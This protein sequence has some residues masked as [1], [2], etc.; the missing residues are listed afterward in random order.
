MGT[1]TNFYKNPSFKY[2]KDLSLNSALQNLRAY[3]VATGIA[4]PT[5][6]I[7]SGDQKIVH[8][9]RRREKRPPP[10]QNNESMENDG[11][12]SHQDY[13]EKRRKEFNSSRVYH[14]LTAD[15]LEN[16]RPSIHLVEYDSD[17]STSSES[18]E[19]LVPRKSGMVLDS[20]EVKPDH[21]NSGNLDEDNRVKS[22]SEQRFAVPGEPVCVV[23]GKYGEYI[24]D[25]TNDDI[26][27][28]DCKAELLENIKLSEGYLSNQR[29]DESLPRPNSSR[30]VEFGG[31][32]WDHNRLRWSKK[33]SSLCTYECWKCQRPGHLAEDCLV[34]ISKRQYPCSDEPCNQV[35]ISQKKSISIS[36]DLLELY[37]R[38]HQIGKNLSTAKCNGCSRSSTL[39]ACLDCSTTFCDSAGHLS[40]HIRAHPSHRQYYSYKLKRLVKCCKSTCKVTDINELL[41]CHFCFDKAFEKFY[42]MYT[43]TWKGAGLSIIWG[44]ISCEDHFEWHRMNCLN[45]DV[46]NNAYVVSKNA[47][48]KNVQLSDF[49]F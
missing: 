5:E 31:D 3:S 21:P 43:A 44:S 47:H 7:P 1:R 49:I 15:V 26:C 24:C 41:A 36:R 48:N 45:A 17:R 33:R 6:E 28:V 2:N 14:E 11:P 40:E 25:E 12:M 4:S 30:V 42:D 23:C 8:R 35:A 38:C 9:K 27:S 22:R 37:K 16:S 20:R 10:D 46:E 32:A 13:I 34:M 39:A 19:K 18:E 29:Q